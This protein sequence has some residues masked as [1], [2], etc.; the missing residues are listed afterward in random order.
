VI[1]K[2]EEVIR[3]GSRPPYPHHMVEM[4]ADAVKDVHTF[5]TDRVTL[6]R[7]AAPVPWPWQRDHLENALRRLRDAFRYRS[8][9]EWP[10][11]GLVG[12]RVEPFRGKLALYALVPGPV[13]VS[14][15]PRGRPT[16]YRPSIVGQ[17]AGREGLQ[18]FREHVGGSWAG[19][20]PDDE[21]AAESARM[22][23]EW[24]PGKSRVHG[25]RTLGTRLA[26]VELVSRCPVCGARTRD[27]GFFEE[28]RHAKEV[29]TDPDGK[30]YPGVVD[31]L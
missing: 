11:G 13:R 12:L 17:Y 26:K 27:D 24:S 6:V 7:M 31:L 23:L 30:Q 21:H 4:T 29:V 28:H 19:M 20:V 15:Q 3:H 10:E 18:A 1:H 16:L 5:V 14:R 8:R 25:F 2:A 9:K 22:L